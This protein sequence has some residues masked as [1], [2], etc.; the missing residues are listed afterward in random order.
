MYPYS[1]LSNPPRV[2]SPDY[3]LLQPLPVSDARMLFRTMVIFA[4]V[5]LTTALKLP[6]AAIGRRAAVCLLPACLFAPQ[7]A[8]AKY[9]ASLS[10]MKGY[11]S[12]PLVDKMNEEKMVAS[13]LSFAQLVKNSQTSEEKMLGRP[14][15]ELEVKE[16][17]VPPATPS[18]TQPATSSSRR[19]RKAGHGH[20]VRLRV[21]TEARVR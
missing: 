10:E 18:L 14:L 12:S 19:P 3:F 6:S 21:E 13:S 17:E 11:G 5:S 4:M 20:R 16:L 9:R 7:M 8:E 15:T 2:S 1:Q